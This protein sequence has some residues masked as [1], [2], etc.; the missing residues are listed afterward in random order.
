M[1]VQWYGSAVVWECSGMGMQQYG[2]AV[3][4]ECSGMGVQRYG[5][6]AV[7][8]SF[9]GSPERELYTRGEPGIFST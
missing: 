8:A 2:S 7:L 3:V 1:G 9:P 6:A 4:W 5:S